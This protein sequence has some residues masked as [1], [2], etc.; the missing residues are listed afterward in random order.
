MN[1]VSTYLS[2]LDTKFPDPAELADQQIMIEQVLLDDP[3][4]AAAVLEYSLHLVRQSQPKARVVMRVRDYQD[5]LPET[6]RLYG[7]T[8][9]GRETLHIK[10]AHISGGIAEKAWTEG[11]QFRRLLRRV[12]RQRQGSEER[13]TD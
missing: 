8:E 9:M 1:Q 3:S 2:G 13:F 12:A 7:F 10:H 5:P 11:G 6:L 4:I